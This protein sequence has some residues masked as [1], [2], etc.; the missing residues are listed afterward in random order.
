MLDALSRYFYPDSYFADRFPDPFRDISSLY[1]PETMRSALRWCEYIFLTNGLYRQAADR[2]ISYFITDVDIIE[3][4]DDN[5]RQLWR[6]VFD[7]VF[8]IKNLLHTVGIDFMC[9]GNS[10][11][12]VLPEFD[13]YFICPNSQCGLRVPADEFME[14][15]NF[16]FRFVDFEFHGTCPRCKTSGKWLVDDVYKRSPNSLKVKRW[17]PHE[18]EILYDP[19]TEEI[20]YLWRIPEYYK[21][22]IKSGK[23][24]HLARVDL[25]VL[26]AIKNNNLFMFNKGSILHLK[27]DALAGVQ[28][29]GWGLSRTLTN[30]RQA[31]YV[32]VLHRVNEAVALDYIIPL[33]IITPVPGDKSIGGDSLFNQNMNMF[34]S[35]VNNMLRRRRRDPATWYTLPFPV[36]YQIIGGE[37]RQL[38]PV[39][40]INQGIEVLLTSIGIPVELI[41]GSLQVQAAPAALRLFEANW[42]TIPHNYNKVLRYLAK[43]TASICDLEPVV[44]RMTRVSHADDLQR[45][46]T[47]LQLMMG[48]QISQTT[49]LRTVGLDFE[50]EE[51]RKMEEQK[52]QIEQQAKMQRELQQQA[53]LE[54]VVPPPVDQ[55]TIQQIL[56]QQQQQ[57]QQAAGGQPAQGGGGGGGGGPAPAAGGGGGGGPLP[58]NTPTGQAGNPVLAGQQIAPNQPITIEELYQRADQLA[59]QILGLPESQKDSEL[60]RLRK[61]NPVLHAIVRSIMDD[62]RQKARTVGGAQALQQMLQQGG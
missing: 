19:F 8:D 32:Q 2:I 58:P 21:S 12:S 52:F 9:Y 47:R 25:E 6:Y 23:S 27:E 17:N 50:E 33:R 28:V 26:K 39:D 20:R 56:A 11:I 49:G 36:N 45:Q 5:A 46:Y 41:K 31:W 62:Y 22:L 59:K 55:M 61:Q 10:F 4:K 34:M 57:Q 3:A 30:F 38:A 35:S 18:I 54:Q 60:I 1:M 24:Y 44:V 43:T 42:S 13:R 16:K 53:M 51:R 14:K 15:D 7:D 37:A 29:R 40:L 48:G